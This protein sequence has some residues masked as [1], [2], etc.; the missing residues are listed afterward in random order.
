MLDGGP[1]APQ[2][3]P[4]PAVPAPL[5]QPPAQPTQVDQLVPQAQLGQQPALNWSHFRPEF[6]GKPKEDAEAHLLHTN[7]WMDTHNFI[8]DVKVHR[9]CLIL[10][11]EVRLWY[12]SL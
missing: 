1:P 11:G 2:P 9:F 8:E 5:V 6:T 4:V 10:V 12:E 3:P 7:D